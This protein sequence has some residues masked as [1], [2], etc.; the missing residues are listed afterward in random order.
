M[1]QAWKMA[2]GDS[3]TKSSH[4]LSFQL[5]VLAQRKRRGLWHARDCSLRNV[6]ITHAVVGIN[7]M[8]RGFVDSLS[9]ATLPFSRARSVSVQLAYMLDVDLH[10]LRICCTSGDTEREVNRVTMTLRASH[11]L[12]Q[13]AQL[14]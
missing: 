8:V 4:M 2:S 11:S 12:A 3:Q 6:V 14:R 10:I 7:S 13:R 5:V 1:F 9:G